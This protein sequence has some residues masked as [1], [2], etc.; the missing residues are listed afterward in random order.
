MWPLSGQL[1]QLHRIVRGVGGGGGGG[2]NGISVAVGG[3]QMEVTIAVDA[4]RSSQ[5]V[6]SWRD[7]PQNFF[8]LTPSAL[9]F[10]DRSSTPARPEAA[11]GA[12]ALM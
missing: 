9:S 11:D 12:C 4:N 10:A 3:V 5:T 2:D 1:R 8:L 6:T 7:R